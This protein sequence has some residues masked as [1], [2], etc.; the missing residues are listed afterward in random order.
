[1]EIEGSGGRELVEMGNL[2]SLQS[3][4]TSHLCLSQ[5]AT[6][7]VAN[8]TRAKGGEEDG[9]WDHSISMF[10]ALKIHFLLKYETYRKV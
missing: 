7:F 4:G 2:P 1:M 10:C 6:S 3:S 9:G 5:K 8:L